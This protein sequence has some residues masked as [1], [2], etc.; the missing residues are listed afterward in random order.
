MLKTNKA[1]RIFAVL[2]CA[3]FVLT[4]YAMSGR[5]SAREVS[6]LLV[7]GDSVSSGGA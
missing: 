6:G 1:V 5:V 4:A 3:A 7:V 2:L